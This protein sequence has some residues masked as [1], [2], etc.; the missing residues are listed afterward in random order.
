ML[1]TSRA[2]D[3]A[4]AAAAAVEAQDA[5]LAGMRLAKAELAD[6]GSTGSAL[7]AA[8]T[9]DLPA[10]A[11][12]AHSPTATAASSPLVGSA[13][14][15]PAAAA[16]QWSL[17][18]PV[19]SPDFSQALAAQLTTLAR[20]GIQQ[21][22]LQLHP[23]EMGP[24]EVKIVLDG[25][26]AQVD[27]SAAHAHTRQA[28]ESGLPSLAAAL[29]GAGLTLSGGG[30]FEQRPGTPGGHV[31]RAG[32]WRPGLIRGADS[33]LDGTSAAAPRHQVVRGLV[34]VYA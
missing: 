24:I 7:V 1:A 2:D 12:P 27:F 34:D 26:Q 18:T 30:V 16:P 14:S 10:P 23:T 33:E 6:Q 31:I 28:I 19:T 17:S 9:T 20:D 13:A 21:A 22:T 4:A 32:G 3:R 29:H 5:A 11:A 8:G 15:P 25:A